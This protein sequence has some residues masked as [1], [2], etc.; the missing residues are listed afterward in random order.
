MNE[1]IAIREML[2]TDPPILSAAFTAQGWNKLLDQYLRYWR[3]SLQGQRLVLLA[4]VEGEIAGYLTVVWESDYLPFR[5]AG[6]PEIVDFNVLIKFRRRRV[7][8]ALMDAAE[9]RIARR[10]PVAGIGVCLHTDYGA[11][12]VLYARRGYVPD[13]RGV[14]YNDHYPQ[15]GEQVRIGDDLTL[16]L[17]RQLS[18]TPKS[19]TSESH[20]VSQKP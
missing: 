13:G 11:A 4:E 18:R 10:S 17:T 7:G 20:P 19:E 12:Q 14:H 16:Y 6:I 3:E 1:K 2:E 8:T 15:Y 9:Q 5:Q